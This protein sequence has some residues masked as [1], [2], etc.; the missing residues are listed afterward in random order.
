MPRIFDNITHSL[1][2]ALQQTLALSDRSDF[3]VGYFNLRGWKALDGYVERWSGG[4]GQQCRLLVGMQRLEEADLREAL[5]RMRHGEL[6]DNATARR[7]RE[8]V[9][10]AFK[11]QLTWGCPTGVDEAALRRLSAQLRAQKLCVKLFLAHPLHAKLYLCF[12]GDP[13][14]PIIGYLGSSN[15]TFSGLSGNGELNVDVL[16]H[17][18]AQKLA[19]WFEDR[20][21][22]RWCLD[23]SA[24]LAGIIDQSWARPD[25]VPPYHIYLKMAWHLSEEARDSQHRFKLPKQLHEELFPFQRAAVLV[26][27]GHLE[28]RGGVLL[29]DVVGLGKTMMAT[30]LARMMEDRHDLQTLILCPPNLRSM[31]EDY[32]QRYGL[33]GRVLSLGKVIEELPDTIRHRLVIVD[34][35][36]NLRNREGRRYAA[37][38]DY[39]AQNAE[40]TVLLS[41]TPFNKEFSD[42]TNQLRLFLSDDD[43]LGVRPERWLRDLTAEDLAQ[44]QLKPKTIRAFERSPFP[45]DWRDLMRLFLVRRTRSFIEKHYAERDEARDRYFITYAS[46]QRAYFP[47]RV[48]RTIKF[49]ID[50][51][52]PADQYAQLFSKTVVDTIGALHLPRYGLQ[53]YV[54]PNPQPPPTPA[55]DALLADLNRAGKRLLGYVKTNL[56]KRLE[57][58]GHSFLLSLQRHIVRNHILLHAL[59]TGQPLPIGTQLGDTLEASDAEDAELALDLQ[60]TSGPLNTTAD[61]AARGAA[62]YKLLATTQHAKFRWV[63]AGLFTADLAVKLRADAEALRQIVAHAGPWKPTLDAKLE[64][65]RHLISRKHK[66]EKLLIFSQF[67]DTVRYLESQLVDADVA[68]LRAVTGDDPDPTAAAWSF[69]PRSNRRNIPAADE[70]RVLLATDVLSEGQN[71]QDAAIVVNFDLPWAII[72]L[73]QRAGRVDRIGQEALTV[74]CYTFLP[75]DGVEN[76]IHLRDRLRGRLKQSEEVLGTDEAFFDEDIGKTKAWHDLYNEKSGVLDDQDDEVDLGSYALG[77]W[78]DATKDNAPLLQAIETLPDVVFSAKA[79]A[80]S[81]APGAL[82]FLRTAEGANALARVDSDGRLLSESPRAI[83]EAAAC[84]PDT[85]AL[86]RVENHHELVAVAAEAIVAEQPAITGALGSRSGP[87]YKAYHRLRDYWATIDGTLFA[88]PLEDLPRALEDMLRGHLTEHARD[89]LVRELRGG[90]PPE[91]LAQLVIGMRNEGKLVLLDDAAPPPPPQ[92]ICSLGLRAD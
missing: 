16:D 9:A 8:Q 73:I 79:A 78:Q 17:D 32:R 60:E 71:L 84:S 28:K 31:W 51:S 35:S 3:C 57:S 72:R 25:L 48:P 56:F 45:D 61:F 64:K 46:G 65:L 81:S 92:I 40:F 76:I 87:K 14:N 27:A 12:R 30:A 66:G 77:I 53:K 13:I 23:I 90:L 26:A 59:D 5:Q 55:E 6:L 38:R 44:L 29:G 24:E 82:V 85:P 33:R 70:T 74:T 15:L 42:V 50:E 47:K 62:L 69:S 36:H 21:S 63:R 86:P 37:I 88:K 19:H 91:H 83:L 75:A 80:A 18:A 58:C 22:D 39:I 68:Q 43:D 10:K 52:D 7:L 4:V 89:T 20:W 49:A 11:D 1:L 34:E 2:P 54:H 41:A 67:A